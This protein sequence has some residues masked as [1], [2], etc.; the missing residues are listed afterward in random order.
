MQSYGTWKSELTFTLHQ[1]NRPISTAQGFKTED[2]QQKCKSP[3]AVRFESSQTLV[4]TAVRG[5]GC[6]PLAFDVGE[7]TGWG[8]E[9]GKA[10]LGHSPPAQ[11]QAWLPA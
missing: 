3:K 6:R 1:E 9:R 10:A 7:G 8:C 4:L 5:G 11:E 2:L